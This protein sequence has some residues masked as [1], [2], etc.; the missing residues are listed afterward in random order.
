MKLNFNGKPITPDSLIN[1]IVIQVKDMGRKRFTNLVERIY[2]GLTDIRH[3]T[4]QLVQDYLKR[5]RYAS[6]MPDMFTN[7]RHGNEI[8]H[9]MLLHI[10][11]DLKKI[12]VELNPSKMTAK[13]TVPY[14]IGTDGVT[15]TVKNIKGYDYAKALDSNKKFS[16]FNGFRKN[17][18]DEYRQTFI[19][20]FERRFKGIAD[21]TI[22]KY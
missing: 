11:Y 3:K 4:R 21:A 13:F 1:K 18:S 19:G 5:E 12:N 17:I 22:Y 10:V 15:G 8:R 20:T 9:N 14:G 7:L 16:R 6:Y 2:K